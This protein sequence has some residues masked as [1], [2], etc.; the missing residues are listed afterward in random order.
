MGKRR[1][2]RRWAQ[3]CVA[4]GMVVGLA[5]L[6][7]CG[8]SASNT[9]TA[10]SV[11]QAPGAPNGA[12]N[13]TSN[14]TSS[15]Q[16]VFGPAATAAP[17][18]TPSAG[19]QYLIKSLTVSMTFTD[20]RKVASDLQSWIANTDPQST[21]AGSNYQQSGDNDYSITLTVSVAASAYP[22]VYSYLAGY[23]Q[24]HSG[25]MNSLQETVQDVSNDFVDSQSRLKNLRTEQGRLLALMQQ[26]TT[27]NDTLT[28]EQRLTDVE[29]QIEQ[30]EAHLNALTGQTTYYKV[31]IV[32]YPVGGPRPVTPNTNG[33]WNPG[34]TIRDA[35]TA[36]LGFGEGLVSLLIWLAF[37]AVY[38]V[39][40]LLIF[41]L[42]RRIMRARAA[43]GLAPVVA[44]GSAPASS[45]A[46]AAPSI[47][48]QPPSKPE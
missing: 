6:A 33:P 15:G 32:L 37:F 23:A 19:P 26:A 1:W 25:Q 31:T 48:G 46:P 40:V 16:G 30:I 8:A 12:S 5:V 27:L 24:T 41:L 29:G 21:S 9:G 10:H 14:G 28:I 47:P 42:V 22:R 34:Q 38:L 17:G 44:R 18:Q 20:T 3:W 4:I 7:G 36:A 43:H 13:G 39:P 35:F 11:N 2:W 45:T